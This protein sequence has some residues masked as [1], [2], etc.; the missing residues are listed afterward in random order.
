MAELRTEEEQVQALKQWWKENGKSLLLTIAVALAIVA[1][2]QGW[3]KQRAATAEAA[4]ITY[5]NMMD[6]VAGA[7]GPQQDQAKLATARH[8]AG[9]LV[10]EFDG[11]VYSHYAG[12]VLARLAVEQNDL[13][14]AV[15][16]LNWVLDQN[17]AAPVRTQAVI[18]KAR[19]L[20]GQNESQAALDLLGS[21]ENAELFAA[22]R[23]ELQGDIHLKMGDKAAAKADYEAAYALAPDGLL[24]VKIN[25]LASEGS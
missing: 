14:Q 9:E 5:Q 13:E 15:T 2:W 11:T 25:D 12:L 20:A 8:L 4:S 16:Q 1:G 19:I 3:Q 24:E 7:L 22:E 10:A 23:Y 18:G 21:V 6:A 17:P